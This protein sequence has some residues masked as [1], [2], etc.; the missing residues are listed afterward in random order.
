MLTGKAPFNI[1]NDINHKR[2][3]RQAKR[4]MAMRKIE[5]SETATDLFN[6]MTAIDPEVRYTMAQVKEHPWMKEGERATEEE[7]A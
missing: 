5:V 1:A 6:K 2:I 3:L 7:V 4:A